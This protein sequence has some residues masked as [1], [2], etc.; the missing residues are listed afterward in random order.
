M[1]S[2]DTPDPIIIE[3]VL[4]RLEPLDTDKY[5]IA[6]GPYGRQFFATPNGYTATYLPAKLLS[7]AFHGRIKKIIWA[8][9]GSE[10]E[11]WFFAYKLQDNTSTFEIGAGIPLSLRTWIQQLVGSDLLLTSLRVQLGDNESFVAWSRTAW[12]CANVPH[13]LQAKL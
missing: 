13:G 4:R 11:S 10:L 2:A 9:F 12:A 8:S 1:S 7:E 5:V 6:L 3:T